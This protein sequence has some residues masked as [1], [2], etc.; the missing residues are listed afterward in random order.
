MD[1][2]V[3][4]PAP[5][6][7][8]SL[9]VPPPAH[10]SVSQQQPTTAAG[11]KKATRTTTPAK[12]PTWSFH[13]KTPASLTS[14]ISGAGLLSKLDA[15]LESSLFENASPAKVPPSFSSSP[16]DARVSIRAP[17]G[18]NESVAV[19]PGSIKRQDDAAEEEAAAAVRIRLEAALD[20]GWLVRA[21]AR[22]C[23]VHVCMCVCV[24]E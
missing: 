5:A 22:V 17:G 23:S 9:V 8:Q 10:V 4:A 3:Q 11:A 2:E 13:H 1:E 18:P 12:S 7:Q 21:P 19:G 6:P 24:R 16:M 20:S 14:P 15:F